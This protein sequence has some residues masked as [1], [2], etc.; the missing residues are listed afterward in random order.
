MNLDQNGGMVNGYNL[1]GFNNFEGIGT[2]TNGPGNRGLDFNN[3][4]DFRAVP[5]SILDDAG[6]DGFVIDRNDNYSNLWIG[7]F[8][9]DV[10]GTWGFPQ[11]GR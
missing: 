9:P 6:A 10:S 4:A 11:P 1:A 7:T 2:L 8:T 5:A 3:D